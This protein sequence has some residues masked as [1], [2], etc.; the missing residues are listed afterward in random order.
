MGTDLEAHADVAVIGAGP[1]GSAAAT[2]LGSAGLRTVVLDRH[3]SVDFVFG[4]MLAPHAQPMLHR[5]GLGLDG[6]ISEH[7]AAR[8]T[9]S[10]WGSHEPFT[11][12]L[13][14]HPH[15][16]GVRLDRPRFD[17]QLRGL[18]VDAGAEVWLGQRVVR[19][20]QPNDGNGRF[21]ITTENVEGPQIVRC[22]EVVDCSGR[23]SVSAG[24]MGGVR[25]EPDGLVAYA[26]R[27]RRHRDAAPDNFLRIEALPC[28]WLYT[29]VL[30]SNERM[31]V[32]HTD[33]D[34]PVVETLLATR[35]LDSALA[36]SR[37]IARVL[38]F[39]DGAPSGRLRVTAAGSAWMDPLVTPGW[40]AAGDATMSFDPLA[41]QGI[42]NALRTGLGAADALLANRSGDCNA[43]ARYAEAVATT[44]AEY[45]PQWCHYY[46][47]E[48]RWPDQP[49][50]RRRHALAMAS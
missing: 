42:V 30:P 27:Y 45:Q 48:Q 32:V 24:E 8:G 15:G 50:W 25:Y 47:S 6:L 34:M 16:A 17:A 49:F 40:V 1:A 36:E 28:G 31:V 4:E 3:V 37:D 18:A 21:R 39:E 11:H 19:V 20:E 46:A 10:V 2:V 38:A 33:G 12:D 5:L 44:A 9:V 22:D 35:K 14:L 43:L 23:R 41:S 7:G 26:Q 29:L 13:F